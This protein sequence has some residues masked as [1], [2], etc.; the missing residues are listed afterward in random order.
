MKY[1]VYIS[2]MDCSSRDISKL[3]FPSPTYRNG[4]EVNA[5]NRKNRTLEGLDR[6]DLKD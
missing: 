1:G 6:F 3:L 4:G 5:D 2:T